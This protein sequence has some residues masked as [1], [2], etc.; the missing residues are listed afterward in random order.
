MEHPFIDQPFINP[1]EIPPSPL[2]LK[3]SPIPEGL[4]DGKV[5]DSTKG[6]RKRSLIR[7]LQE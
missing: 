1:L 6:M 4:T 5:K 2:V 3:N 7:V